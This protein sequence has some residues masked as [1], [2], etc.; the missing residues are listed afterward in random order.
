MWSCGIGPM[1]SVSTFSWIISARV[2]KNVIDMTKMSSKLYYCVQ[3]LIH[4]YVP[5]DQ[6]STLTYVKNK[7]LYI[8]HDSFVLFTS[9]S[10]NIK[11]LQSGRKF[12]PRISKYMWPHVFRTEV[13]SYFPSFSVTYLSHYLFIPV[14]GNFPI[15]SEIVRC[16][17]PLYVDSRLNWI[18]SR[19]NIISRPIYY[20]I[21]NTNWRII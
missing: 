1:C 19:K 3:F 20:Q 21:S 2:L 8:V 13:G 5:H 6:Q 18:N 17:N 10:I 11:Y 16:C 12:E 4:Q 15:T 7:T 14:C 9:K